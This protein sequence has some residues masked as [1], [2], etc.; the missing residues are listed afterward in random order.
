MRRFA[1]TDER[2]GAPRGPRAKKLRR[3][4]GAFCRFGGRSSFPRKKCREIR[5]V[6]NMKK[7]ISVSLAIAI[8]II[9]MTVTFSVTIRKIDRKK[10]N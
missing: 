6:R 10:K 1:G 3:P 4:R 2:P 5:E 9:A 7:K 8:A